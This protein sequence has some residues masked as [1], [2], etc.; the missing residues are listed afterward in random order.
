MKNI[1]PLIIFKLYPEEN[2]L[3]VHVLFDEMIIIWYINDCE[4]Q[5]FPSQRKTGISPS[6]INISLCEATTNVITIENIQNQR[7]IIVY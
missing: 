3:H 2:K 5:T 1:K 6:E 4:I 7:V